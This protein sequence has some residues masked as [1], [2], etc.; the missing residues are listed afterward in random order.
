MPIRFSGSAR[1]RKLKS[2][3]PI[4]MPSVRE[5]IIT[6]VKEEVDY[7]KAN[8]ELPSVT[9][10][11][12]SIAE[13]TT[14]PSAASSSRGADC[15]VIDGDIMALHVGDVVASVYFYKW[16]GSAWQPTDTLSL[17]NIITGQTLFD[18]D[19]NAVYVG[20]PTFSSNSG[21][22][23][24]YAFDFTTGTVT[25][26]GVTCADLT[27]S[28]GLEGRQSVI[29]KDLQITSSPHWRSQASN[30]GGM[31]G[32]RLRTDPSARKTITH[33]LIDSSTYTSTAL[34]GYQFPN[35]DLLFG[36]SMD[37]DQDRLLV[38]AFAS[39]SENSGADAFISVFE[40]DEVAAE[41]TE[42]QRLA[43]PY[44]VPGNSYRPIGV[45]GQ[46]GTMLVVCTGSK[47]QD[48]ANAFS[49]IE[50]TWDGSQYVQDSW[51]T[52]PTD[53]YSGTQARGGLMYN[54]TM[55]SKTEI[56]I[57]Y[58]DSTGRIMKVTK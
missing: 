42:V 55:L 43:N 14:L 4:N 49:I 37:V 1:P 17:S 15:I 18:R 21:Q 41:M 53:I 19:Y 30:Y 54:F 28:A 13:Y 16:D 11:W 48:N 50:Y 35:D 12:Q 22:T 46:G 3:D 52:L 56:L 27:S 58:Q 10:P 31:I 39:P 44:P 6:R 2:P 45:R 32:Y 47:E 29:Y 36:G 7:F 57:P 25:D 26:A 8:G 24:R 51:Y 5:N 33:T 9:E 38:C 23:R 20:R 34:I 40:Y